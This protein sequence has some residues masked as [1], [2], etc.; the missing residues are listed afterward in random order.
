MVWNMF[1]LDTPQLG[2]SSMFS[3][4]VGNKVSRYEYDEGGWGWYPRLF[5]GVF[6]IAVHNPIEAKHIFRLPFKYD[7]KRQP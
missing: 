5:A 2:S 1:H 3:F 4:W 7:S 6:S